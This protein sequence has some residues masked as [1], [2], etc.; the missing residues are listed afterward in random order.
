MKKLLSLAISLCMIFSLDVPALAADVGTDSELV[1]KISAEIDTS[2]FTVEYVDEIPDGVTP[3]AFDNWEDAVDWINSLE[4]IRDY[5]G[6]DNEGI[7]THQVIESLWPD[8]NYDFKGDIGRIWFSWVPDGSGSYSDKI[9]Y[10]VPGLSAQTV[11]AHHYFEYSYGRVTDWSV[12]VDIGGLG[13]ATYSKTYEKLERH[14]VSGWRRYF[15]VC[16]GNLGYYLEVSGV[17]LGFYEALELTY[18]LSR[19]I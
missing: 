18:V 6:N 2:R 19:Q 12:Y 14:D 5:H 11:T 1:E 3:L 4:Q 16:V 7:S 9:V 13:L 8:E 10:D 15:G 17:P